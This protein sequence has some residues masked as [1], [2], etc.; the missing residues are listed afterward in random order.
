MSTRMSS[1]PSIAPD[2]CGRQR[3]SFDVG[4]FR[5]RRAADSSQLF[6]AVVGSLQIFSGGGGRVRRGS[7]P[8][9]I[10]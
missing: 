6:L 8:R 3:I 1:E 4:Y 9:R 7:E 2:P 10:G 5:A